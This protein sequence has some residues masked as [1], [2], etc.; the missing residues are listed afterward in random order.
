MASKPMGV[1]KR[2]VTPEQARK[3]LKRNESNRNLSP[4]A[5]KHYLEMMRKGDWHGELDTRPIAIDIDGNLI[6]GQH[7]LRAL[8]EYNKALTFWVATNCPVEARKVIDKGRTR[9]LGN[10]LQMEYGVQ[11][12]GQ[13]AANARLLAVFENGDINT[14]LTPEDVV[15]YMAKY[16]AGF[17]WYYRSEK[18]QYLRSAQLHAPLIWLYKKHATEVESFYDGVRTGQGLSENSPALRL[19]DYFLTVGPIGN[20]ASQ[21]LQALYV[22]TAFRCHLKRRPLRSMRPG[23][24]V[25]SFFRREMRLPARSEKWAEKAMEAYHHH[26]HSNPRRRRR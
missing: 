22:L 18:R 6:D 2:T 4:A 15:G 8:V 7:R 26:G 5:W 25:V 9:T 24:D 20:R 10:T 1:L 12:A 17:D 3:W 14:K 21:A 23:L 11:Y 19:R 16:K 13:I